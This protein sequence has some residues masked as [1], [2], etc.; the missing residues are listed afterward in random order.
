[1]SVVG[2]RLYHT[3]SISKGLIHLLLQGPLTHTAA[4]RLQLRHIQQGRICYG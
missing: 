4:G 2:P 3:T 1:M